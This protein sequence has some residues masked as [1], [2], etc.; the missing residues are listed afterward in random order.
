MLQ[1]LAK[2]SS[3]L[4]ANQSRLFRRGWFAISF[5]WRYGRLTRCGLALV[6]IEPYLDDADSRNSSH[7]QVLHNGVCHL[8][9]LW[10]VTDSN[11]CARDGVESGGHTFEVIASQQR[12]TKPES[13][14]KRCRC[15]TKFCLESSSARLPGRSPPFKRTRI[16][17]MRDRSRTPNE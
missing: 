13:S 5:G 17:G 4:M 2:V 11:G 12:E 3:L 1:R 14:L 10:L 16:V 6:Q 9:S 8:Q 7:A 15:T